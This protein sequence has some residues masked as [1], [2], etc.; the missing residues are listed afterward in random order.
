[1]TEPRIRYWRHVTSTDVTATC[2][3]D[4]CGKHTDG[5]SGRCCGSL[6]HREGVGRR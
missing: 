1:M 3:D 2:D 6:D 4:A 5:V